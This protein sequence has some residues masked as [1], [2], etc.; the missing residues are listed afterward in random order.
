MQKTCKYIDK[1]LGRQVGSQVDD[2][3]G[4]RKTLKGTH[5]GEK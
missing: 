4:G 3:S 5:V 1:T 2:Q